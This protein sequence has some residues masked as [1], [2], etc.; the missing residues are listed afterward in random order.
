MPPRYELV[1]SGEGA[2]LEY[3]LALE[4]LPEM[5]TP[6]FAALGLEKL[7]AQ[8]PDEDVEKAL[9]R[10]AESQRKSEPVERPER[11]R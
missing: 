3:T 4:V 10:L 8:I 1:S 2:D 6:D 5:P 9:E 7:V 11:S